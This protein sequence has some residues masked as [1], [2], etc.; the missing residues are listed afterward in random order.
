MDIRTLADNVNSQ[1]SAFAVGEIQQLRAT[2]KNLQRVPSSGIF[3][4]KTTFDSWAFHHGGRSE[5]QFNIGSEHVQGAAITRYGVAF[6][7]V[8]S[9]TLPTIDVLVPKVALFN[10]YVRTNPD[11]LSGLE[12]WHSQDGVRSANHMPGLISADLVRV[13]TFVFLGAYSAT[14]TVNAREVL[15]TFDT[16]LPLYQFVESGGASLGFAP[17]FAFRSGN[18]SKK[19]RTNRS[20]IERTLSV[21]L[22]HNDLQDQ[23]HRELCDEFGPNN[24]GTERPSGTG[25]RIDV[26][27]RDRGCYTFYEIKVGRGVQALIRQ[28]VGQL[29]EYSLWPGATLPARVVIVGEP[30]L[31][32][33]AREYLDSLNRAF[34]LQLSYRQVIT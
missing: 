31:S 10:E 13:N 32:D 6:S 7:F 11:S 4:E 2:L 27:S 30:E 15:S 16:L 8:P 14:T 12:M 3:S 34:P 24:V 9:R 18:V 28:A 17:Q 23:L 26:V 25:G 29:L 20:A 1:S 19:S 21:D 33:A 22:R 5:L